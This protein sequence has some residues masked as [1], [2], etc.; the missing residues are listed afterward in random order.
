MIYEDRESKT[1]EFKQKPPKYAHLIKT[2][3]AFANGSGGDIILGIEDGTRRIMGLA[4]TE[5]EDFLEGFPGAVHEA[6][7]PS[8]IPDVFVRNVQGDNL[9]VVKIYPGMKKPYF[10]ISEGSRKGVYIRIGASTRR[11]ADDYIEEL[12]REQSRVGFDHQTCEATS[13]DL[14]PDL[15]KQVYSKRLDQSFMSAEQIMA[16]GYDGKLRPTRAALLMFS[17]NPDRYVP[18]SMIICTHF[19]GNAGRDIVQTREIRGSIQ[20]LVDDA[21]NLVD[22]WTKRDFRLQGSRLKVSPRFRSRPSGKQSS[23][24]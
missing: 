7:T 13:E 16:H 10:V 24:L 12:L 11:A 18:E 8:L 19:K 20:D 3:V 21:A 14:A 9:L 17:H 4:A 23:M 1:L 22:E 6:V 2:C 15:L 5:I